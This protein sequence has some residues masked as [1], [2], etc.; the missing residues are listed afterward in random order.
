[1]H[2]RNKKTIIGVVLVILMCGGGA[3][4]GQRAPVHAARWESFSRREK[5]VFLSGVID[6]GEA[7]RFLETDKMR[8]AQE[9]ITP[10]ELSIDQLCERIDDFYADARNRHIPVAYAAALLGRRECTSLPDFERTL[11]VLR[12]RF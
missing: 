9:R 10:G 6:G 5:T 2:Q 11:S 3:A 8:L 12:S 4:R 1:M 7:A